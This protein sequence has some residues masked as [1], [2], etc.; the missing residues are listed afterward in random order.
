MGRAIV[1]E[2][3]RL[4]AAAYGAST[5]TDPSGRTAQANVREAVA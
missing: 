5:D 2:Q 3:Q 1:R 4:I